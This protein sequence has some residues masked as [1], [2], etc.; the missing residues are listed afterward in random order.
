M[1]ASV[2]ET[3]WERQRC[4]LTRCL[5]LFCLSHRE[6]ELIELNLFF[7]SL[8]LLSVWML[9]LMSSCCGMGWAL[10]M[11]SQLKCPLRLPDSVLHPDN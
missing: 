1:K 11:K 6:V 5:S 10:I 3:Q 7:R 4:A 9:W 2:L 8:Y